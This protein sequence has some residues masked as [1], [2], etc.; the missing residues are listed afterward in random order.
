MIDFYSILEVAKIHFRT[1][2]EIVYFPVSSGPSPFSQH[3]PIL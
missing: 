3:K 2:L 1:L